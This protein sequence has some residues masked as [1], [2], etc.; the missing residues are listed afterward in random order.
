MRARPRAALW[1]I[2]AAALAL[3]ALA[4]AFAQ[5]HDPL[6]HPVAA[7]KSASLVML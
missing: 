6:V 5:H 3:A 7:R 1:A 4:P 2:V